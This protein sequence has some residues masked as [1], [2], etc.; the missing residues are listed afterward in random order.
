[1]N[2]APTGLLNAVRTAWFA[3]A[4]VSI[5][6]ETSVSA[7]VKLLFGGVLFRPPA[8]NWRSLRDR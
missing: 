3:L 2:E 7:L 5:G 1:M 8:F 4:C 6:L